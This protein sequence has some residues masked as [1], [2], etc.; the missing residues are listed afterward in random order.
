MNQNKKG[1]VIKVNDL[2][3]VYS[4]YDGAYQIIK[5]LFFG[6]SLRKSFKL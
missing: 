1:A 3:K 5:H 4:I 2:Y 6:K